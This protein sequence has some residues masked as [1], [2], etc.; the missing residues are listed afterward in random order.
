M[1]AMDVRKLKD[2]GFVTVETVARAAQEGVGG[3]HGSQ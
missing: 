1:A 2:A 3:D